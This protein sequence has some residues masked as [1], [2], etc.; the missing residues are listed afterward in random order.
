MKNKNNG[1]KP[2]SFDAVSLL[3]KLRNNGSNNIDVTDMDVLHSQV[4]EQ[5]SSNARVQVQNQQL[6]QV[7]F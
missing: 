5:S 6:K 3:N 2:A 1:S 4:A 7:R